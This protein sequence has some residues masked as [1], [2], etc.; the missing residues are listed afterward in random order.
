VLGLR[1]EYGAPVSPRLTL[2][3][4]FDGLVQ[5]ANLQ[6]SGSPTLPPREGDI[7]AFG[8][9]VSGKASADTWSAAVTNLAPYTTLEITRGRWRVLPSL[10]LDGVVISPNRSA[11]EN[12]VTPRAGS[13]AFVL[14]A[15]SSPDHRTPNPFLV[16]REA[17]VWA[18]PASP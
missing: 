12:G 13:F 2:V 4:G 6:R 9:S 14:V 1:G 7:V 5:L 10:R 16:A 3:V 17:G 11:P 15:V 18:V 8:Q